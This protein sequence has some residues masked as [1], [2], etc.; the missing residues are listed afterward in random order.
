MVGSINDRRLPRLYIRTCDFS[1]EIVCDNLVSLFLIT[2]PAPGELEYNM[3]HQHGVFPR[4][5]L[6]D[7]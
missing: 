4:C 2:T 6:A 5:R 3:A 7:M 1:V